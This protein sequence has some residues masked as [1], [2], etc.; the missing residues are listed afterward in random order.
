M[1]KVFNVSIAIFMMVV[2]FSCSDDSS[3]SQ[4]SS[5]ELSEKLHDYLE[6]YKAINGQQNARGDLYGQLDHS[7]NYENSI[8]KFMTRDSTYDE[9]DAEIYSS[10]CSYDDYSEFDRDFVSG[11]LEDLTSLNASD[12]FTQMDYRKSFVNEEVTNAEHKDYLL[13]IVEEFKW[14][15]YSYDDFFLSSLNSSRLGGDPDACFDGCMEDK[16]EEQLDSWVGW[17]WFLAKP[18]LKTA[19]WTSICAWD[20]YF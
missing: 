12:F 13:S 20:C 4:V 2:S 1:K 11:I 9:N 3:T 5:S 18:A 15:M 6:G 16:I 10:N 14:I 7:S 19:E 8:Y 17:V